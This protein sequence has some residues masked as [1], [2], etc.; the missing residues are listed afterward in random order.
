MSVEI[1]TDNDDFEIIDENLEIAEKNSKVIPVEN[2]IVVNPSKKYESKMFVDEKMPPKTDIISEIQ[3]SLEES[4]YAGDFQ[5]LTLDFIKKYNPPGHTIYYQPGFG[6][7]RLACYIIAH[8]LRVEPWRSIIIIAPSVVHTSFINEFKYIKFDYSKYAGKIH[9]ISN[10]A[11]NIAEQ[12]Y[13]ITSGISNL[14]QS[15]DT[16]RPFANLDEYV[17]IYDEAQKFVNSVCNGSKNASY[18]YDSIMA[19]KKCKVFLLTGSLIVKDC[20]EIVPYVNLC[21]RYQL[22]PE[23]PRLFNKY[24][25][26]YKKRSLINIPILKTRLFGWFSYYGNEYVDKTDKSAF[27]TELKRKII[28]VRMSTQQFAMYEA[29]RAEEI[30]EDMKQ[31]QLKEMKRGSQN[32][33]QKFKKSDESSSTYRIFSRQ[34]CNIVP[35][36]ENSIIEYKI[37]NCPKLHATVNLAIKLINQGEKGA[38]YSNFIS[39]VGL[40]GIEYI[41]KTKGFKNIDETDYK[42]GSAE[43]PKE[44]LF[45]V[46]TGETSKERRD[47]IKSIFNA[48][49]NVRGE[50]LPLIMYSSALAEGVGFHE[51]RFIIINDYYFNESRIEQVIA[52]MRRRSG[53][54]K[55]P[56]ADRTMRAYI[57]LSIAPADKPGVQTTDEYLYE[58][59]DQNEE[60]VNKVKY[61]TKE[62]SVICTAI[63]KFSKNN[64]FNCFTCN[65]TG[66]RMYNPKNIENDIKNN[67]S[68]CTTEKLA[69]EFI[70]D[71]NK[72]YFV[73]EDNKF[74]KQ[75]PTDHNDIIEVTPSEQVLLKKLFM[76]K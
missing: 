41:L 25:M 23:Y 14:D 27:A 64:I 57:M 47:E 33:P 62:S 8:Y 6:K 19:S 72:Y 67:Y 75:N 53:H 54:L 60:L 46:L 17:V 16:T 50:I 61:E 18:V 44:R 73:E 28:K 1:K 21:T 76:K 69:K 15:Q 20:F 10:L 7:T 34:A 70:H 52:R 66:M 59:A 43:L 58:K 13:K 3:S 30:K 55:L 4:K 68:P 11:Y 51:G 48:S 63:Q 56:L 39:H 29:Y 35:F 71:N 49:N 45:A 74:Y 36:K 65:T 37:E 32:N 12:I 2:V 31:K 5:L 40:R 42:L 24:F 9:F 38:I 26:N 22:L